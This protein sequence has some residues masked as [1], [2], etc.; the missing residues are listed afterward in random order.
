MSDF[1]F[2]NLSVKLFPAEGEAADECACCSY[3]CQ[4][5]SQVACR[6]PSVVAG[7]GAA[8][9]TN[10]T[11]GGCGN[12]TNVTPGVLCLNNCTRNATPVVCAWNCSN[13]VSPVCA[14]SIL[15][16]PGCICSVLGAEPTKIMGPEGAREPDPR[17]GLAVMKRALR[18][19]LTEIEEQERQLEATAKPTT[20]EEIDH[21]R[22]QLLAAVA[23]LDEQRA[24]MEG[25]PSQ[26]A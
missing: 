26:P 5:D 23:E 3:I 10:I 12:C 15:S 11:P 8:N 6:D 7:C 4:G 22:S 19:R 16:N 18:Q 25:G 2:K 20:V 13:M 21:V 9:C 24:A 14:C 17:A 1:V